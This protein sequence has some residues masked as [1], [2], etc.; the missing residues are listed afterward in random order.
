M[1]NPT[2]SIDSSAATQTRRTALATHKRADTGTAAPSRS[3]VNDSS[4]GTA[5][6]SGPRTQMRAAAGA[7][8]RNA[9]AVTWAARTAG[10][11]PA[12]GC[13]GPAC[14][15]GQA[16][17][18]AQWQ[19]L[20]FE[21]DE[22]PTDD[23]SNP[24]PRPAAGHELQ[25]ARTLARLCAEVGWGLRPAHQ[26]VA[27]SSRHAYEALCRRHL[28]A[29]SVGGG[30]SPVA[31]LTVTA[32]RAQLSNQRVMECSAVVLTRSDGRVRASALALRA[33]CRSGSWWVTAVEM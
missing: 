33:V 20:P 30:T 7:D 32:V 23:S 2:D 3:A 15:H 29:K 21:A 13:C 16:S 4:S 1:A 24:A 27:W 9:T 18:P 11:L 19:P 17:R 6:T 12:T 22:A 31:T 14:T 26:C 5:A 28:R 8:A 10:P 25:V